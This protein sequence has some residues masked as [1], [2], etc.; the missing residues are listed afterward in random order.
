WAIEDDPRRASWLPADEKAA[1]VA[2]LEAESRLSAPV[3][4]HW[5]R[6]LW[7]PAVLLLASYNFLAL[8]AEWGVIFWLPTVLKETG[9]SIAMV[10]LLS[11]I[12]YA[13]GAVTMVLVAWNSDRRQERKWH[14]I[15]CTALSG[16][17]LLFAQLVGQS[18]TFGILLFLT[19]ATAAFLGRFGPFWTLPTE[20]LPP[21]VAGVAIGLVNGAGNLGGVFGPYF[22]GAIRTATGSFSL[23]LTFGGISLVLGSLVAAP[24]R[25]TR[26]AAARPIV[27]PSRS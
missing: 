17:F 5:I 15:A 2:A 23:A 26:A 19:L 1:L 22:F 13:I 18:N 21:A 10:G 6:T 4:G 7:R 3:A 20:V 24:I 12:P 8:M 27:V 11:A 16:V 14:M 25:A 9:L